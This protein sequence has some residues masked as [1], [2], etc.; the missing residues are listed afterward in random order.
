MSSK[1]TLFLTKDNEHFYDE[2][3]E[4]HY[5]RKPYTADNFIGYTVY[6]EMSKKNINIEVNDET[7]L[8]ISIK[9]GSELY[10]LLMKMNCNATN[11]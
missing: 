4:P 5:T 9:P 7:D 8:I 3:N 6:L 1:G 11:K 10:D 2:C